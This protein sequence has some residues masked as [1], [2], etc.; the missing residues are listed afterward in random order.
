MGR[1]AK[2][3]AP[4]LMGKHKPT[5]HPA[6]ANGGDYVV[7]INAEKVDGGVRLLRVTHF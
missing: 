3:I 2:Q 5:Y 7:V 1:L 4:I 6:F